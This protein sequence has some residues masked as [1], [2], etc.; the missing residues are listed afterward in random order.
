MEG[1]GARGGGCFRVDALQTIAHISARTYVPSHVEGIEAE[2]RVHESGEN[3]SVNPTKHSSPQ[4]PAPQPHSPTAPQ[5]HSP[6]APQ[7]HSP[8]AP[9]PHS[10]TAPHICCVK[11]GANTSGSPQTPIDSFSYES[12]GSPQRSLP[13]CRR[14][15]CGCSPRRSCRAPLGCHTFF[16]QPSRRPGGPARPLLS[17]TGGGGVKLAPRDFG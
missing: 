12:W 10:P 7:P 9:Q 14:Q 15:L 16:L 11:D 13:Q 4:F 17:D 5:P 1:G 8:T 2:F 3:N 6:T